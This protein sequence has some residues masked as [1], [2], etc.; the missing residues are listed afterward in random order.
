MGNSSTMGRTSFLAEKLSISAYS[1][2][3][4]KYEPT[5]VLSVDC[6]PIRTTTLIGLLK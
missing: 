1:E 6:M 3:V 2:F 5:N 4:P